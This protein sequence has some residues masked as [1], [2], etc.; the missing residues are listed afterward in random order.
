MIRVLHIIDSLVGGGKERQFIEL[1][2]GL[3]QESDIT[4]HAVIMSDRI[5]YPEFHDLKI[6][7]SLLPRRSRHDFS[8]LP[9][10]HRVVREFRPGIV[11]SWNSMCSV[12][13]APLAKV[14][15]AAFVDGFVRAA[16]ANRDFR[17]PDYFRSRFTLPLTSI[18]VANSSAGLSAY[19]I[20]RRKGVCIHNGFDW[21]RIKN[22]DAP[23]MVRRTLDIET[24]H[25]VGM[26]ATFSPLKDYDT[27]FAAAERLCASRGDV[28]FVAIGAGQRFAEYEAKF[29]RGPFPHIR[30]LGRRADVENIVSMLSV[31]VLTSDAKLH[32]E[33]ISNAIMEYMA[34]RKP[35]VATECGGNDELIIEGE[36]GYLIPDRDAAALADRVETL[37]ND[38]A[39]AC[40]MGEA[41]HH[42]IETAFGLGR[43][44]QEYSALYRRLVG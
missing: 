11:Q 17:D 34:L 36:T 3:R 12:Y 13:A 24:P 5:E 21:S 35:A 44:T 15:G 4:C 16:A 6:P 40:R 43:M 22:I 8:I 26:V 23:D 27:F 20:P 42:R 38:P 9:R 10:L 14:A 25:I 29:P 32:G 18:V 30:L 19:Q 33:G 37:L 2:K 1:L 39:L 41:G 31:G 7:T 28:T